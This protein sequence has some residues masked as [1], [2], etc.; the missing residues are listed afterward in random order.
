MS[1]AR[2]YE[3]A[4]ALLRRYATAELVITSRLHCALPCRAM[5]TP[6]IF[7]HPNYYSDSRFDGLRDILDG[8]GPD[9]QSLRPERNKEIAAEVARV[10]YEFSSSIRDWSNRVF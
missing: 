5:G 9:D 6:V 1:Y 3:E 2:K 7:V 10:Q 8:Y 4:E